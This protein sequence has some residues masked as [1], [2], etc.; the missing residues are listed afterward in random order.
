MSVLLRWWRKRRRETRRLKS[1]PSTTPPVQLVPFV[2]HSA[3]LRSTVELQSHWGAPKVK[4]GGP[5]AAMA[6][7]S[8][9]RAVHTPFCRA[10]RQRRIYPSLTSV[11]PLLYCPVA[12]RTVSSARATAIHDFARVVGAERLAGWR[13][14]LASWLR[15][16]QP[17]RE[18]G[19]DTRRTSRS[20]RRKSRLSFDRS[21]A[22]VWRLAYVCI[23]VTNPLKNLSTC[24]KPRPLPS[25]LSQRTT[26]LSSTSS[27]RLTQR[28]MGSLC[29]PFPLSGLYE[30]AQ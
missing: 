16:K 10:G 24:R 5:P 30:M 4:R 22:S 12:V 14:Y 3:T 26:R 20:R 6:E 19:R 18:C 25:P 1:K 17:G 23:D 9:A 11:R 21:L 8:G 7:K 27:S 28:W 29:V 13:D 2:P 15:M